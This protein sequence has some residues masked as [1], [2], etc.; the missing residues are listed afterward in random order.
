MNVPSGNAVKGSD[1][2]I[3][4]EAPPDGWKPWAPIMGA[5]GELPGASAVQARHGQRLQVN[6]CLLHVVCNKQLRHATA[7]G[8][9][10]LTDSLA[11]LHALATVLY[12][13][14]LSAS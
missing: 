9:G 8:G 14:Q 12:V 5:V 13:P 7:L 10:I 3:A 2:K 1:G 4:F 6:A 11:V